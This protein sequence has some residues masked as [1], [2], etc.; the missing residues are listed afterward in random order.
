MVNHLRTLLL[1]LDGRG[2]PGA[3]APGEEYVP[4]DFRPR[5]M[6]GELRRVWRLLFG[7]RPDRAYRNYRLRQYLTLVHEAGLDA[8]SPDRRV[9]YWPFREGD[10]RYAAYGAVTAPPQVEVLGDLAADDGAGRSLFQWRVE[11]T[12]GGAV[13]VDGRDAGVAFAEGL[14]AAFP[15]GAG[16]TAKARA[17]A[18]VYW[19]EAVARPGRDL[20]AVLAACSAQLGAADAA[21]FAGD[22]ELGELWQRADFLPER[23]GAVVV[24]LA[25]RIDDSRRSS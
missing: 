14:S 12:A 8:L 11:V 3:G 15:L 19:V 6:P 16:L 9:S 7:L 24:A 4:A 17:A 10:P 25:R 13:L 21:L 5:P 18:G 23:L 20:G 1:D 2:S 22:P